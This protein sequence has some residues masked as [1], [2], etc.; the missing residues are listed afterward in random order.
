MGLPFSLAT[1]EPT[2]YFVPVLSRAV[3]AR[4]LTADT[5]NGSKP[6]LQ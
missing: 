4:I 6:S 1:V 3:Y 2:A 5:G